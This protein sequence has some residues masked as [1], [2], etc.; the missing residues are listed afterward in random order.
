MLGGE[1]WLS[2]PDFGIGDGGP[3]RSSL[4]D[5]PQ[6]GVSFLSDGGGHELVFVPIGDGFRFAELTAAHDGDAVAD[7]EKFGQV[8]A[9]DQNR[10]GFYAFGS[11]ALGERVDELI[12]LGLGADIDASGRLIEQQNIDVGMQEPGDGYFLLVAAAE[13]A[14]GLLGRLA[15]NWNTFDPRIASLGLS[16]WENQATGTEAV[17]LGQGEILGDAETGGEALRLAVFANHT[18]SLLPA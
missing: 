14:D 9:D 7:P 17:Q 4:P 13:V 5:L 2:P 6:G 8:A 10:F 16:R 12:N 11:I 1:D 3:G 15:F 18:H